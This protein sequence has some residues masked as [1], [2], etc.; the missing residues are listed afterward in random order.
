MKEV[1]VSA[2]LAEREA[3]EQRVLTE[4]KPRAIGM[5]GEIEMRKKLR[6]LFG[7]RE[8]EVIE[9]SLERTGAGRRS[10]T[11]S[12]EGNGGEAA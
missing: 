10:L 8:G 7:D 11:D 1:S 5:L 2:I 12:H 6:Q 4:A 9:G 3:S